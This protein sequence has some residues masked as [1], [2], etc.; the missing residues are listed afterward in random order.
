M[1]GR[2]VLF[3]SFEVIAQV[4]GLGAAGALP[5]ASYNVSPGRDVAMVLNDGGG[6]RLAS[7]IWGF[8]PPWGKDLKE[9]HKMINARAE[10]I[11]EKPSFREAFSSHRCLI[12]ADGFYEWKSVQGKK[13]PVYVRLR[14]GRPFGMVGL[15]NPWTSPEGNRVC[16]CTI[17]TTEANDLLRPFHDRMPVIAQAELMDLWLDPSV[18]EKEKLLPLLKPRPEQDLELY[19]VSLRVNSPKN[20]SP[21]NIEPSS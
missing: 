11:A 21:E 10:T 19:E 2:F 14:S 5:A 18:R 6:N 1:C 16:T 4:F 13:L 7:C 3:S 17:I 15:Y 12:V 20:D 9:G 8:V